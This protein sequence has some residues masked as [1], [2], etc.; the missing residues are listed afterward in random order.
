MRHQ[1][2]FDIVGPKPNEVELSD[3]ISVLQE[4]VKA[5]GALASVGTPKGDVATISLVGIVEGSDGLLLEVRRQGVPAARKLARAVRTNRYADLPRG[6]HAALH[7]MS[8]L[9]RRRQWKGYRIRK[10]VKLNLNRP[11]EMLADSVPSP[12]ERAV[13][14]GT[15]TLLAKCLRAG[16]ATVP[17]AELRLVDVPDLLHIEVSEVIARDLGHRLYDEVVLTGEAEWDA[18]SL[19]LQSFKAT[20]VATFYQVPAADGFA[21][22][23]E[24]A[25]GRWNDTDAL[26]FIATVRESAS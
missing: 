12:A 22:L 16:G 1:F 7:N 6:A 8:Q 4:V 2:R 13:V 10:S 14:R 23:A 17:K 5:I 9:A 18:K 25:K 24:I 19:E 11:A 21:R 20:E 26:K 3:L 15:T